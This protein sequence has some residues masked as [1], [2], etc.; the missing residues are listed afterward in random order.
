MRTVAV[1]SDADRGSIHVRAADSA[2]RIGGPLPTE[3][4]LHSTRILDAALAAGAGAVHPGYGFLSE[5]ADFAQACA[6]KEL[7]F[8]G[9]CANVIRTMGSK[10]V[11]RATVAEAGVPVVPGYHGSDQSDKALM[12]AALDIGFPIMVKPVMGGGGKGMHVVRKKVELAAAIRTA[13]HEALGAFGDEKL[14]LEKYISSSRHVEVQIFGDKFGNVVHL[15]ER[16]CSVQRRHQKI[17]EE[18]PAPFLNEEMRANMHKAAVATGKQVGYIGAGTVEFIVDTTGGEQSHGMRRCAQELPYHPFYFLEMNTRLQVEHPVTEEVTGQ[19]LVEWQLRV[20]AGEQLPIVSQSDIRCDGSAVEARIYAESPEKGFLPQAGAV[21]HISFSDSVPAAD[22]QPSTRLRVDAGVESGKDEVSV[23]YDPMIAKVIAHG[24][25]RDQA[26]RRLSQSLSTATLFG[27]KS[28][29][30]FCSR[31]LNIP[32]FVNGGF[33]TGMLSRNEKIALCPVADFHRGLCLIALALRARQA[34]N[35][36][37][38]AS[39][40]VARNIHHLFGFQL[41]QPAMS[42]FNVRTERDR[43]HEHQILVRGWLDKFAILVSSNGV[44]GRSNEVENEEVNVRLLER[45]VSSGPTE[46]VRLVA[47]FDGR[48]EREHATVAINEGDVL[49]R[50]SYHEIFEGDA[51][52]SANLPDSNFDTSFEF[53]EED[54]LFAR[55]PMPGRIVQFAVSEGHEVAAGDVLFQVEAMKCLH[56]VTSKIDATVFKCNGTAGEI[57][58]TDRILVE[59]KAKVKPSE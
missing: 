19:D 30:A 47:E 52:M 34:Q 24:S 29:T 25:T 32:E 16:D 12:S 27:P 38:T 18:A 51:N 23:F 11:A 31:V 9:P 1:Y 22:L 20:A 42:V 53:L 3:S 55:S 14:L 17:I 37:A 50:R 6:E 10:S 41:N 26:R 56:T 59:L 13:R 45:E 54:A 28:N 58:D 57:V 21:R 48:A 35:I 15:H 49:L 7:V 46:F 40:A 5:N 8:V 43:E 44:A 39:G 33:D 36:A 2:Y 4:Y